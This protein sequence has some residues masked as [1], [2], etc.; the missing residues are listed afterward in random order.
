[1]NKPKKQFILNL[2]YIFSKIK[3]RKQLQSIVAA[4]EIEIKDQIRMKKLFSATDEDAAETQGLEK[5]HK[6]IKDL[7]KHISLNQKERKNTMSTS[8]TR[9]P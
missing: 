8:P 2:P 5:M 6:I 1:M 9:S 7:P 4:V 3:S